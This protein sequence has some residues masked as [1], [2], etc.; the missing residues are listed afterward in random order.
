M[1]WSSIRTQFTCFTGTKVQILTQKRSLLERDVLK[2]ALERHTDDARKASE[3]AEASVATAR[4]TEAAAVQVGLV[5]Q[6]HRGL[7]S[8]R[9]CRG[10]RCDSKAHRGSGSTGKRGLER[11]ASE[12]LSY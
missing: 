4:R 10:V 11:I 2:G 8:V 9:G 5:R 7:V 6:Q 1:R 3:A 12:A